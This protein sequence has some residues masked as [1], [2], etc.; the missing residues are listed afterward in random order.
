MKLLFL[1]IVAI[2]G[3]AVASPAQAKTARCV[4][5]VEGRTMMNGP[6]KFQ[7]EDGE[8]SFSLSAVNPRAWLTFEVSSLA[9]SVTEPGL[10]EVF[11]VGER[12]SRWGTARRSKADK[13]C[14]IGSAGNFKICAY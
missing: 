7:R 13:A 2:V 5:T 8:G 11:V 12:A 9:L 4:V 6:C 3:M 10:A 1:L 14:W